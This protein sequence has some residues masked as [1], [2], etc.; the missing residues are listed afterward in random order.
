MNTI[1]DQPMEVP[2]I[3]AIE[4]EDYREYYSDALKSQV[5]QLYKA[6]VEFGGYRF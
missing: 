6:D 5:E 4:H 1:F 2:K 3:G